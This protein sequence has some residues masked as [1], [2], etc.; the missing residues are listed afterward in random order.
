[1]EKNDI[2]YNIRK[3]LIRGGVKMGVMEILDYAII[4]IFVILFYQLIKKTEALK[5]IFGIVIIFIFSLIAS[6]VGLNNTAEIL[7]RS[8]EM[9]VVGLVVIFHPELRMTLK[10][11][12]GI[13]NIRFQEEKEVLKEIET[14]IFHMAKK[15]VGALIILDHDKTLAYQAE[16][17]TPVDAT[18]SSDLLETIFHPMTTLHDGAVI[19]HNERIA[20]AG[21]KLPLSGR[22][23][24]GLGHL[25]TRHLAAIE[26]AET[27]SVTAIVVSEETGNISVV[28]DEGLFRIKNEEMFRDFFKK[29]DRKKDIIGKIIK[30]N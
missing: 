19:I 8:S 24:E 12:G 15:R 23:R 9:L 13:T 14:A 2:S 1:L 21:C 26:N 18:C 30:K 5:I 7:Q 3:L 16:N 10:K 20:Y 4:G 28:T 6:S 29:E 11:I 22:K 27:F 17:L 25:G